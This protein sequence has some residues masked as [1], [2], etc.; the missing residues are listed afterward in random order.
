MFSPPEPKAP[1]V[2]EK[3]E[4]LTAEVRTPDHDGAGDAAPDPDKAA[5]LSAANAKLND[6]LGAKRDE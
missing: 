1:A 4:K 6:L 2:S 5:G 3:L